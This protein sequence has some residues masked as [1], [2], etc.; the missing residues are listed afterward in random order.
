MITAETIQKQIAHW[1]QIINQAQKAKT[2]LQKQLKRRMDVSTSSNNSIV[3][4]AIMGVHAKFD[5]QLKHSNK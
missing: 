4:K 2:E 3:E 5:K 1:D